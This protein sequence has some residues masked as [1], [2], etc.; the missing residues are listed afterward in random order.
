MAPIYFFKYFQFK[1]HIIHDYDIRSKDKQVL[2]RVTL[3]STKRAFFIKGQIFLI[4]LY[5]SSSSLFISFYMHIL[6]FLL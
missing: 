2:N 4:I 1:R 6:R 5:E 3:E